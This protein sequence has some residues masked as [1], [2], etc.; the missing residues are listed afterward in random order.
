MLHAVLAKDLEQFLG[1]RAPAEARWLRATGFRRQGRR[2]C[3][4]ARRSGRA[5]RRGARAWARGAIRMRWR[6][7]PSA[8][9]RALRAGRCARAVCRR[10]RR[11]CLG[12]RHL[13]LRPLSRQR[14]KPRA[15]S[16]R[17]WCCPTGVDGEAV[18]RIAEGVF[19]ARDLINTPAND[20]GPA[21]LE[22]GGAQRWRKQFGARIDVIDRRCAARRELSDDPCGRPRQHARAAADRSR[23]GQGRASQGHAGR[24]GRV[25]RHRRARSQE[26]LRHG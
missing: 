8:C 3:S 11:L 2:T 9:R 24:Q 1:T 26:F 22:A 19:L 4:G 18:S 7:S 17:G 21:E 15:R 23:L 10:A 20:M 14:K 12:D 6:C 16:I 5:R 25:L 13:C